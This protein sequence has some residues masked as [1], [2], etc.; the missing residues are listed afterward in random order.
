[1]ESW[2]HDHIDTEDLLYGLLVEVPTPTQR[3]LFGLHADP[4]RI[5]AELADRMWRGEPPE[6]VFPVFGN[7]V[8]R[9]AREIALR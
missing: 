3:I 2:E 4:S 6:R 5:Q 9:R 1:M 7:P 8:E